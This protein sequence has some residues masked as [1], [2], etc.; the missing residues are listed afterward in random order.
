[1]STS[2]H[3]TQCN[4]YV[5]YLYMFQ[6]YPGAEFAQGPMGQWRLGHP[7]LQVPTYIISIS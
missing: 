2:P 4:I 7:E 5:C 1:M 3:A 6:M